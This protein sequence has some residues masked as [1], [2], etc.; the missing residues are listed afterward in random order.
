MF[1]IRQGR[2]KLIMG[3]GSGGWTKG[4]E[5]DPA[6][7]QLYDLVEDFKET[8]NLYLER[9]DIVKRMTALLEKYKLENR[10]APK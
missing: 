4:G 1:A 10:S 8:H 2:W 9:P 6:P 7:G 3:K 5:N